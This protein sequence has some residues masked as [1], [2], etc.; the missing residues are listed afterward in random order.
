MADDAK[1]KIKDVNDELG[2]LE[3]Q[4]LSI[5][6]SLSNTIKNA[7]EDIKDESADVAAIFEKN[8]FRSIKNIAKESDNILKNT[9]KLYQ[10]TSKVKD[11]QK[12][13]SNLLLKQLASQRNIDNLL[14]L[15]A[16]SEDQH[17]RAV[18]ELNDAYTIQLRLLQSQEEEAEK[19]QKTLG[20]TGS[21]LK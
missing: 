17:K 12:D 10:G 14:K 5:A 9:L 6:N 18:N 2:N 3:D 21:L 13:V 20:L 19:I 7:I 8:L 4:L 1:K 11:I 16:I 15:G